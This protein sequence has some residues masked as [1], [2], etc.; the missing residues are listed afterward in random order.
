MCI[1]DRFARETGFPLIDEPT[2]HLDLPGRAA[3]GRYLAR[4]RGFVLVSHDRALLD[5]CV[6]HVLALTANGVELQQGGYSAWKRNREYAEACARAR[7]DKADRDAKRLADAARRSAGWS[8]ATERT[9]F[10]HGPG[11]LGT[12]DRGFIGHKAAKMM[13]RA[14]SLERRRQEAADMAAEAARQLQGSEEAAP[15][16]LRPLSWG[17]GRVAEAADLTLWHQAGRP[18]CRGVHFALEPGRRLAV[19]GGNGSG[20]STLLKLMAGL[21]PDQDGAFPCS[22][23]GHVRRA[24]GITVSYVAQDAG[25]LRGDAAA[26]ARERGL[27]PQRFWAV[28]DRLGVGGK[29]DRTLLR[30]DMRGFSD[31]QR[32]KVLLAAGL[33][34]RAHLYVW[35]EPLNFVDIESREQIEQLILECQPTMLFVEHDQAFVDRV[36]TDRL[37]L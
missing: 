25:W 19:T 5:A 7:R 11:A 30:R 12:L 28:L 10:G 22:W 35:D 17:G 9:K 1:R 26:F 21:S 27:D 36:A 14:K 8:D 6:D 20:K 24:S 18:V 13:K 31:G 3:L 34:A 23:S 32:K 15:L 33:C 4:K 29:A 2:N 16:S 37:E